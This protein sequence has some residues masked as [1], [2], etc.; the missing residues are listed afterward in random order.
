MEFNVFKQEIQ[1]CIKAIFKVAEEEMFSCTEMLH[2]HGVT[3][4]LSLCQSGQSPTV[5]PLSPLHLSFNSIYIFRSFNSPPSLCSF[6]SIQHVTFFYPH[7]S[8]FDSA[9]QERLVIIS[10]VTFVYLSE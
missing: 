5:S 8:F 10:A 2:I 3:Y 6:L 7:W 9:R 1:Q 4:P